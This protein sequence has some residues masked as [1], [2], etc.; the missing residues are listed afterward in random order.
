MKLFVALCL[1]SGG[2]V[3][4]EI[5]LDRRVNA[6]HIGRTT[7]LDSARPDGSV[8]GDDFSIGR[9]GETWIIDR[10]RTWV[11]APRHHT[12]DPLGTPMESVEFFGGLA[13]D[14]ATSECAC[15]NLVQMKTWTSSGGSSA[16]PDVVV[17]P[18]SSSD[19]SQVEFRN[20]QWSVPGGARIQFA[21]KVVTRGSDRQSP[22]ER[23]LLATVVLKETHPLRIFSNDG[24]F[25]SFLNPGAANHQGTVAISIQVWGHPVH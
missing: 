11:V 1:L 14:Q 15:H 23:P 12:S 20:L 25:K 18:T 10:I 24:A 22:E 9:D 6:R 5:V 2:C 3:C 8:V 17:S 13:N 4:E 21:I 16:N 19:L 7:G